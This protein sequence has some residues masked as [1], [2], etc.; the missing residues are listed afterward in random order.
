MV[1][2]RRHLQ[3]VVRYDVGLPQGSRGSSTQTDTNL[4]QIRVENG[5][6]QKAN[7]VCNNDEGSRKTSQGSF[8]LSL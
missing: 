6:N 4:P 8:E 3:I 5:G 7:F 2:L 1:V